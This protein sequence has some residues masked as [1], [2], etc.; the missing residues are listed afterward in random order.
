MS[1]IATSLA[2]AGLA[3]LV[4]WIVV[5]TFLGSVIAASAGLDDTD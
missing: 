5:P 3:V 4:W 1:R 2:A